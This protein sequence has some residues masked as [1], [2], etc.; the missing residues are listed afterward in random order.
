MG[1]VVRACRVLAVSF[2]RIGRR[3]RPISRFISVVFAM[4]CRPTMTK[5]G[6]L[7]VCR[8]VSL[9]NMLWIKSKTTPKSLLRP[10]LN[11]GASTIPDIL[12]WLLLQW[13]KQ[14]KKKK[15]KV[16]STKRKSLFLHCLS[17]ALQS[18]SRGKRELKSWKKCHL[19]I[20]SCYPFRYH[21]IKNSANQN[22]EK[23]VCIQWCYTQL[24][25]L[26]RDKT[27]RSLFTC[28]DSD[29]YFK[30]RIYTSRFAYMHQDSYMHSTI[31]I[32]V[33]YCWRALTRQLAILY[34]SEKKAKSVGC[35]IEDMRSR[36]C[37]LGTV[38]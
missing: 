10:Y 19:A 6:M 18:L 35:K 26:K 16:P 25:L 29:I 33:Y 37:F 5:C 12:F 34:N 24:Y 7:K 27:T 17:R 1:Y 9:L 30:I 15:N 21:A 4:F 13:Y 8:R 32:H 23:P 2:R 3:Y 20:P 36:L 11:T 22:A 28:Q 14:T 38:Q 31:R